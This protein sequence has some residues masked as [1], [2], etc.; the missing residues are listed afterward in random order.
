MG[1]ASKK[2]TSKKQETPLAVPP[3]QGTLGP[4]S[5]PFGETVVDADATAPVTVADTA[6]SDPKSARQV[7][8]LQTKAENEKVAREVKVRATRRGYIGNRIREEGDVFVLRMESGTKLPSWVEA[9][10]PETASTLLA[11]SSEA[12][13]AP[14]TA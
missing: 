12:V 3:K 1:T 10:T 11:H 8:K 5:G 13:E 4:D 6:P 14:I 9:V 7:E 2:A